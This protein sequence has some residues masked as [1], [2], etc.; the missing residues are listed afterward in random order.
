[1]LGNLGEWCFTTDGKPAVLRGGSFLTKANDLHCDHR[2][3]SDPDWQL[4]DPN[5]PKSKWWLSDGPFVGFRVIR[6]E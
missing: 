6:E 4:K 5:D 2:T 1:M 3:P